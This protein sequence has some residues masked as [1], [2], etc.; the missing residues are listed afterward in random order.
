MPD[1]QVVAFPDDMPREQ[2][3]SIIQQKLGK[4]ENVPNAVKWA[5]NRMAKDGRTEPSLFENIVVGLAGAGEGAGAVL[6]RAAN[7]ATLGGTDYVQRKMGIDPKATVNDMI[8]STSSPATAGLIGVASNFAEVGGG[9]PVGA[10][11]YKGA[12]GLAS[13][14]PKAAQLGAAVGTSGL[15]G[16]V[17][18]GF[19]SD[20]DP[21]ITAKSARDAM[22]F[23]LALR[24]A[25]KGL[26]KI[27]SAAE[28][29][30]GVPRGFDGA[31]S[32]DKGAR[33]LN[34]AVRENK[35]IAKDVYGKAPEA[36]DR[37]NRQAVD[38]I[39]DAIRGVDIDN[40]MATSK[41]AYRDYLD[42]NKGTQIVGT[43]KAKVSDLGIN[44]KLS[45]TQKEALSKAWNA[46]A[47]ELKKG[48]AVGSLKHIDEMKKNL[49]TMIKDSMRPKTDGIGLEDTSQ[50]VALR[51]L[52]GHLQDTMN[53]A[54][55][56]GVNKQY[57]EAKRLQEAFNAGKNFNPNKN[58]VSDFKLK[59]PDEQNAFAQGLADKAKLNPE[60]KNV[61]GKLS[62]VRGA[63]REVIGEK[64]NPL[65]EKIDNL[66]RT[67]KNISNLQNTA[68][69]K[70][71]VD[72]PIGKNTGRIIEWF[73]SPRSFVG[74]IADM[75]RR[76]ATVGSAE[77][78]AKYLLN[79]NLKVGTPLNDL[80]QPIIPSIAAY[81]PTK[82]NRKKGE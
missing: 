19:D 79:P 70:L 22:L 1:G 35:N 51:E 78:A 41:L 50:T 42:A 80:I 23:D 67:Y 18:G 16:G 7:G 8:N 52:K 43:G 56:S 25:G 44:E 36:L 4:K 17:R 64:A 27:Y 32:D 73:D 13:G 15:M 59:T 38:K 46:G 45:T 74:G 47:K 30:K 29:I 2:I 62:D 61:A 21:T 14:L 55:L 40:K 63:M 65:F 57:Q 49:N 69:K 39:D 81:L 11:L 82:S 34:R 31:A 71:V 48:E 26:S 9:M 28:K 66:D 24:G 37:V 3:S 53:K 12:M 20:F 58:R 60:S 54:G 33:I 6:N 77:R 10:G 76:Y 72:D 5:A 75:A 68:G